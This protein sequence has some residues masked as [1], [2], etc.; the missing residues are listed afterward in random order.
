VLELSR[1]RYEKYVNIVTK[2]T[3]SNQELPERWG[4]F[5]YFT[6]TLFV[7]DIER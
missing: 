7:Q 5:E 1:E 2:R 6:K 4:K 3:I